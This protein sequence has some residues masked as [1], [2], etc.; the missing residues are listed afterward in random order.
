MTTTDLLLKMYKCTE[1]TP[2]LS[3]QEILDFIRCEIPE[4]PIPLQYQELLEIEQWKKDKN[5]I[6]YPTKKRINEEIQKTN[7]EIEE[8]MK[9]KRKGN[10]YFA[11][12][13]IEELL[14]RKTKLKARLNIKIPKGPNKDIEKAK[15][16]PITDFIEFSGGFAR[17][18]FHDEKTASMH[19]LPTQNS[20]WCFSCCKRFDVIDCVMAQNKVDFTRAIKIILGK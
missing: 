8:W 14:E 1:L 5:A 9:S 13:H 11:D 7:L 16:I 12:Y 19:L 18:L 17:C 6:N 20:V 3:M 10:K 15:Q 4:N 2:A